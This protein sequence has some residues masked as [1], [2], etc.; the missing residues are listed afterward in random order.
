MPQWSALYCLALFSLS[1][2]VVIPIPTPEWGDP[3]LTAEQLESLE[4]GVDHMTRQ[5]VI[6]LAG[7]PVET[8]A[9]D[10][11]LKYEW[12]MSQGV[13]LWAVA[14][15][16]IGDAGAE[17][18]TSHHVLLLQFSDQDVLQDIRHV[19]SAIGLPDRNV[20]AIL[21]DWHVDFV[22]KASVVDVANYLDVD[23]FEVDR[24]DQDSMPVVGILIQDSLWRSTWTTREGRCSKE[25]KRTVG[26]KYKVFVQE[27]LGRHFSQLEPPWYEH[28]DQLTN[29][30][31]APT[32]SRADARF[33]VL[34]GSIP[35]SLC[36]PDAPSTVSCYY[37]G[38]G[39]SY[40]KVALLDTEVS[41]QDDRSHKRVSATRRI[42]NFSTSKNAAC[43]DLMVYVTNDIET[44]MRNPK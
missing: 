31:L 22:S 13:Y 2:C 24:T 26:T 28:L 16:Y 4:A 44:L 30:Q 10:R 34:A 11:I 39:E 42:P 6:N 8:F 18:G 37:A 7:Q 41:L 9:S 1:G 43:R 12:E 36:R 5:E 23:E 25:L 19:D 32:E 33:I 29:R 3:L 38:Y 40:G 27:D 15:T 14:G 21:E 20:A 17:S 35:Q